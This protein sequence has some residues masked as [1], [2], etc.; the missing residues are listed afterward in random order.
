MVIN[1]KIPQRNFDEK[2]NCYELYKDVNSVLI[3]G[4]ADHIP[5]PW[6]TYVVPTYKRADLLEETLQS[7][8]CQED[9]DKPWD[10]IVVDNE[11]GG[12]NETEELIKRINSPKILYFRNEENIGV[13]GNYNRC[14]E[15]A[16]GEWIGMLH[17]DDLIMSDHLK[18]VD[19]Y[20]AYAEK[21]LKKCAYISM[22]YQ[23][24][25]DSSK[26]S[27][28]R[29]E[30]PGHFDLYHGKLKRFTKTQALITGY[31]VNLPSFGTVINKSIFLKEGGFVD[32]M[33]LCEDVII[34]YK[35]SGKYAVY[36]TSC[37]MGFHRNDRNESVKTETIFRI[38]EDFSV[39]REYMYSRNLM[40]KMWGRIARG[41]HFF[42][43]VN[44]C[45]YL[46]NLGNKHL[47]V[48]DFMYIY[49]TMKKDADRNWLHSLINK[50]YCSIT[51]CLTFE[52]S[53]DLELRLI[54]PIIA[55]NRGKKIYIYGAGNVGK[56][57]Y[58]ELKSRYGI[59]LEGFVVTS[60][61]KKEDADSRVKSIDQIKNTDDETFIIVASAILG[62]V[63]EM[64]EK[65]DELGFKNNIVLYSE[66]RKLF[67]LEKM[68]A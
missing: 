33:G 26:I 60:I 36:V 27:L 54:M 5:N 55:S 14:I 41:P 40:S 7:I 37:K 25:V 59:A 21:K 57:I 49:P 19:G 64:N 66:F 12:E 45:I 43:L 17:A 32:E 2:K 29:D 13:C 10:I 38:C 22:N 35:L 1:S 50:I 3:Y 24:F 56:Y 67:E 52:R 53:I 63:R 18:M 68:K 23:D 48:D 51:G 61:E 42:S 44:Y 30:N 62:N 31:S 47:S 9:I 6:F 8:L 39:F 34:P 46:S 16:R 4:S 58:K 20:I 28:L 15:L 65:L 11:A